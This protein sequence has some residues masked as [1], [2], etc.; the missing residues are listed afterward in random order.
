MRVTLCSVMWP[1]MRHGFTTT[2][3]K[4]KVSQKSSFFWRTCTNER[5]DDSISRKSSSYDF[6]GFEGHHL[7]WWLEKRIT[8]TGHYY[9]NLLDR[10]NAEVKSKRPPLTEKNILFHH[11]DAAAHSLATTTAKLVELH[12][13]IS[14]NSLVENGLRQVK[15]SLR[16]QRP[17]LFG[18]SYYLDGL[19]GLEHLWI[20]C[21]QLQA[22]MSKNKYSNSKPIALFSRTQIFIIPLLYLRVLYIHN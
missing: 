3:L 11:A 4:P 9:A 2:H 15:K 19:K 6:L 14:R 22:I 17:I 5:K 8:I 16:K 10:F 21:T 20:K 13:W 12:T 1:S 18:K 7:N